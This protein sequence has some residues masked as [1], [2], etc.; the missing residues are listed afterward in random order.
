MRY[1]PPNTLRSSKAPNLPIGPVEYAQRYQEQLNNILRLYFNE[2][3]GISS[4]LLDFTGGKYLRF[5]YGAVQ[6]T[7]DLTFAAIDTAT[8]VTCDQADYL[9]AMTLDGTDGIHVEEP[10]IYNLQFSIQFA[11]SN[12]NTQTAYV[13]FR[14]NGTNL[15]GTGSKFDV[16]GK[17]G[18]GDGYLIAGCNFYVSLNAGDYIELWTAVASTDIYIEAYAEQTIG[19]PAPAPSATVP[20]IPSVVLTLSFVS[21]L[22]A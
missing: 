20:A 21:A 12:A 10:G 7:T 1:I 16:P 14:K 5:P 11:N 4:A 17:H 22:P 2:L 18:T 19:G 8:L 15:P 6:R 9:N 3:D 13:W